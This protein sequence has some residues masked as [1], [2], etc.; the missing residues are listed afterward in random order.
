M[1]TRRQALLG[2]AAAAMLGT[3]LPKL[4]YAAPIT[5]EAIAA[6]PCEKVT[7]VALPLVHTH[8]QI[9]SGGPQV[10]QFTMEI[11]E[12]PIIIDEQG[13]VQSMTFNGSIPGPVMVVHRTNM[14]N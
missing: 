9:A 1:F 13:T 11:D 10:V 4:T 2:A 7:L 12:K 14:S 8:D 3:T 5:E 6:L